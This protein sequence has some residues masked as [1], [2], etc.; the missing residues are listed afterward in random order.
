[1]GAPPFPSYF[2]ALPPPPPPYIGAP[3]QPFAAA[4]PNPYTIPSQASIP[5]LMPPVSTQS[6]TTCGKC[7]NCHE[8]NKLFDITYCILNFISVLSTLHIISSFLDLLKNFLEMIEYLFHFIF[9]HS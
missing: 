4:S 1:M 8:C 2:G 5:P 3:L 6:E 7:V 9:G